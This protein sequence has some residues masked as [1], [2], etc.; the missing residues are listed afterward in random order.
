[1]EKP[2]KV[3]YH[4]T[5]TQYVYSNPNI[6]KSKIQRHKNPENRDLA[7]YHSLPMT[8]PYVCHI[9]CAI[10]HVYTPVMLASIPLTWILWVSRFLLFFLLRSLFLKRLLPGDS[11]NGQA[12]N[13]GE[14][15]LLHFLTVIHDTRPW[16]AAM[17]PWDHHQSMWKW[18]MVYHGIWTNPWYIIYTFTLVQSMV[19]HQ[20]T[21]PWCYIYIWTNVKS[22]MWKPWRPGTSFFGNHIE[23]MECDTMS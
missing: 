22:V 7:I 6:E 23:S 9:W 21:W 20:S 3:L 8:D 14:G 16:R 5:Y 18:L 1:M 13:L 15:V 11:I 2:W 10:C 19:H 17:V 12:A 4:S